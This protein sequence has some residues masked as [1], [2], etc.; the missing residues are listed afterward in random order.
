MSS[1][2]RSCAA[3]VGAL[4]VTGVLA[5]P[6]ASAQQ[7]VNVYLGGFVP[8][9]LDARGTDDVLFA[10][11][12]FLANRDDFSFDL[13]DFNGAT[14]GAEWLI[15]VNYWVDAGFG[16]G[17]YQQTS[18]TFYRDLVNEDGSNIMQ[19][20]KLRIV[21]FTATFRLLPL[22]RG[23]SIRPYIGAGIGVF[24]WRYSETG[25]FVDFDDTIFRDS[26][27]ADGSEV[28]PVVLGGVTFPIGR[29]DI[30]GEIRY[31][32]AEGDLPSDLGFAGPTIDLGGM[33]YL[34]VFNVR[35]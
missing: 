10:N 21:P 24:T 22:G 11:G 7:S 17:Y 9:G 23:A 16:L 27:A 28:G 19:D 2:G 18:N 31:Q 13:G 6:G 12:D 25:Q 15:P 32:K 30:G 8:R 4:L 1:S 3:L 20:L 33:S 14:F 34:V 26:F 5:A 35:F 29:T